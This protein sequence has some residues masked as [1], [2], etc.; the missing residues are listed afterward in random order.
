MGKSKKGRVG[1]SEKQSLADQIIDG[2]IVK[3]KN[4]NK[5]RLRQDEDEMV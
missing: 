1:Y 3:G 5:V 4:R 2:R